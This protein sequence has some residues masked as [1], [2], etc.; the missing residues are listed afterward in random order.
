MKRILLLLIAIATVG[1]SS[2]G[3]EKNDNPRITPTSMT[4]VT[5]AK[6]ANVYEK[7]P[8]PATSTAR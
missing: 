2:V 1:C 5:S 4:G 3:P 7:I 6:G 8:V